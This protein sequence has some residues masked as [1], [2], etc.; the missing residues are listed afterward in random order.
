[1]YTQNTT[2]H[3]IILFQIFQPVGV[4]AG[5]SLTLHGVGLLP[6]GTAV[7]TVVDSVDVWLANVQCSNVMA[8]S[9]SQT[10]DI[11]SCTVPSNYESGFYHVDVDVQ[12]KGFASVQ[13]TL[14]RPGLLRNSSS[15][16]SRMSIYPHVFL[17]GVANSLSPSSGGV[18]G[19][20]VLTIDGSGFSIAPSRVSVR[21]GEVPCA[22]ISSTNS[23]IVCITGPST[24]RN[25]GVTL[26][27]TVNGFPLSIP[28]QFTYSLSATPVISSLSMQ[29][30]TG[31]E[32]IT[33]SGSQFGMGP[34]VHIVLSS[35][36]FEGIETGSECG[37]VTSN[38]S[39]IT[40]IL[41]TKPAGSYQVLV[42][43]ERLGYAKAD[44]GSAAAITFTLG[45]DDFSPKSGGYGGGTVLAISGHGFPILPTLPN[46]NAGRVN[47]TLCDTTCSVLTSAWSTLTCTLLPS[48]RMN[49]SVNS[50]MSCNLTVHFNDVIA[51]GNDEFVFSGA[52]T[53]ILSSIIPSIGGTAG[54]T[55]VTLTGSGFY[56]PAVISSDQLSTTD[57]VVSIDGAVCEWVNLT[58]TNTE[59][60][61]RTSSH[62]TTLLANVEVTI[63]GKGKAVDK[64]SPVI[65]EYID[66]W[67]S[68]FTWGGEA[69]PAHGE[70]VHIRSG[71][72]IFLDISPPVLNLILIEGA[73][74]FSDAQDL[75][76]QAK[77][78][79]VNNGTL[80]VC[81]LHVTNIG[82]SYLRLLLT[83]R[84]CYCS[85]HDLLVGWY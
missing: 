36:S 2:K 27:V 71:Q 78:I 72:T 45:I 33:I 70:S 51:T 43:V 77:Y 85:M 47:I 17:E 34:Q 25:S 21:I 69:L 63:N 80:Q 79:F 28:Q 16:A 53:P 60:I 52:L 11:I 61:C 54:G 7:H 37:V 12:G 62:R 81:V 22:V 32:N 75:H 50:A 3:Y 74:I 68:Q 13:P 18:L 83:A 14:L 66:L 73:L 9:S 26:S 56:P 30:A 84:Q 31:G 29:H 1:M 65:F 49:Y 55:T 58:V 8:V 10:E 48:S 64:D 76:L 4:S 35:E 39:E 23:E 38:D 40:C 57:I 24:V 82:T 41:P 6:P 20:S 5:S 15:P 44:S 59:I 19:G 46:A 42:I 67:S